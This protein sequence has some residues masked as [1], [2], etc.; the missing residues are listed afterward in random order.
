MVTG[1]YR[2]EDPLNHKGLRNA[3]N[4]S[5]FKYNCAGYAL[6]T[7]SWYLPTDENDGDYYPWGDFFSWGEM[8]EVTEQSV[9]RMLKDFPDLRVIENLNEVHHDEYAIAFRVSSDGDFHYVRQTHGRTWTHKMGGSSI[10]SMTRW[11]VFHTGWHYGRYD[12]P[13]V[14]FAKK[15]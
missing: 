12:G 4:T 3:R 15:K 10:R 14:L 13:I 7:I 8:V 9:N 2:H 11:E 5:F 6:G 1:R